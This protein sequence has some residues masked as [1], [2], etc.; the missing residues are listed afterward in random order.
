MHVVLKW[1]AS[2][3]YQSHI[4]E[5]VDFKLGKVDYVTRFSNPAKF[6]GDRI[7]GGASTWWWNIRATCLFFF[8]GTCTV[9]TR[10]PIFTHN[11]L[12]DA[13]W[14][15]GVPSKQ[16]FF[17]IFFLVVIFPQTLI[18]LRLSPPLR[19]SQLKRKGQSNSFENSF[20]NRCV[21]AWNNLPH[22]IVK[23]KSVASFKHNLGSIDLSSFLSYVRFL[24]Y[25]FSLCFYF[26]LY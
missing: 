5:S 21:S 23:S 15:K 19:K 24:E 3:T 2:T 11:S 22:Y 17:D 9:Y 8:I 14:F 25:E 16:V 18:I 10:K 13:D 12:K 4:Y 26:H 1:K 20:F 7:S 6:G